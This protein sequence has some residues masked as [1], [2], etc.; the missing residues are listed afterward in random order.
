MPSHHYHVPAGSAVLSGCVRVKVD[1]RKRKL[2]GMMRLGRYQI[3]RRCET[4]RRLCINCT[5]GII[6]SRRV[7]ACATPEQCCC[8][9]AAHIY[10]PITNFICRSG[11]RTPRARLAIYV[12]TRAAI[13]GSLLR[14]NYHRTLNQLGKVMQTRP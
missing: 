6:P 11:S 7:I 12:H 13:Y 8:S 2:S 5:R 14:N 4:R 3:A 9:R 10:R 1:L